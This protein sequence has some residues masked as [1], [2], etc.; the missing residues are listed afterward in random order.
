MSISM[1]RRS[2]AMRAGG[3]LALMLPLWASAYEEPKPIPNNLILQGDLPGATLLKVQ[4]I[5][6]KAKPLT[7]T[8]AGGHLNA[9]INIIEGKGR[10]LA[11][12]ATNADGKL[13]YQ[14]EV[15]L[16]VNAEFIPQVSVEFKSAL[17]DAAA[18][19]T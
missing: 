13:I 17:D 15:Q 18:G 14:G 7:V 10:R 6:L 9:G 3:L 2:L 4:T 12:S 8:L 19:L 5:G 16:D 1:S 11:L